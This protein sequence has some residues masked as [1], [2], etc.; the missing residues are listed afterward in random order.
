MKKAYALL[1]VLLFAGQGFAMEYV[2]PVEQL[3]VADELY[4]DFDEDEDFDSDFKKPITV[5]YNGTLRLTPDTIYLVKDGYTWM[6]IDSAEEKTIRWSKVIGWLA[7]TL[8]AGSEARANNSAF[9]G[10]CFIGGL[11]QFSLRFQYLFN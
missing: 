2:P 6:L 8:W 5:P 7:F 9:A 4:D 10:A 1:M 3:S 11:A